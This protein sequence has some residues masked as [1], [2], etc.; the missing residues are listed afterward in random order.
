MKY[1]IFA[2]LHDELNAGWVWIRSSNLSS[3]CIVK[4]RNPQ[5]RK[6]VYCE[7]LQVDDNF[8]K[9][10]NDSSRFH[11]VDSSPALVINSWYRKRLGDFST[12]SCQDLEITPAN[13]LW[14]KIWACLHHPQVIVRIATYLGLLSILLGFF[15]IVL[16]VWSPK[17]LRTE[18][19]LSV[20]REQPAAS[21][22][23]APGN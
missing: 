5:N 17:Q 20:D 23:S 14:G 11:I 13:R 10:Y 21:R 22:P 1:K 2:A 18:P 4:I 19:S 9:K 7:A 3:R 12:Q 15:S 16:A 6:K 8:L